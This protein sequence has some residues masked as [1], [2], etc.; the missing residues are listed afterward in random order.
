M[1]TGENFLNRTPMA[2]VLRSRSN[3]WYLKKLQVYVKQ[4][5]MLI[6]QNVNQQIGKRTL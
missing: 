3:K 5:T 1:G 4:R 2:Y 6:G